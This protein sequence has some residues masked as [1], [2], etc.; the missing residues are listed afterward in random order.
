MKFVSIRNWFWILIGFL[1]PTG[2][3]V[4]GYISGTWVVTPAMAAAQVVILQA[5][6][7]TVGPLIFGFPYFVYIGGLL[8]IYLAFLSWEFRRSER[9]FP[10]LLLTEGVAG[11]LGIFLF[12]GFSV[13]W[14]IPLLLFFYIFASA[15]WLEQIHLTQMSDKSSKI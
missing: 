6:R 2:V 11:S 7:F 14:V 10:L 5:E 8:F 3:L 4:W 9:K 1:A 13:M 12:F 15:F